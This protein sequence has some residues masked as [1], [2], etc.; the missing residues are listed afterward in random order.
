M[1]RKE[2]DVKEAIIAKSANYRS[3]DEALDSNKKIS[4]ALDIVIRELN[5]TN[6]SFKVYVQQG[7]WSPRIEIQQHMVK[8]VKK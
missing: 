2:L 5:L 6:G 4:D 7:G 1:R 3:A 8:E